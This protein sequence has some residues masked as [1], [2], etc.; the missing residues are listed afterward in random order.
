MRA[1]VAFS[2]AQV[3]LSSPVSVFL[4]LNK[5][6]NENKRRAFA[7][8]GIRKMGNAIYYE[9]EDEEKI[10]RAKSSMP[11]PTQLKN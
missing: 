5:S 2:Q 8:Y 7:F 11:N 4:L 3:W 10:I 1:V 6:G 9:I